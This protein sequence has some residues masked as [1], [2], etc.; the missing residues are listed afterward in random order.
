MVMNWIWQQPNWPNFTW[1]AALVDARLRTVRRAQGELSGLYKAQHHS[2][3]YTLDNLLADLLASCA[4][5]GET[6]N[7][8]SV[9]SS[10]A[11]RLG[12]SE[13]QPYPVSERSEGLADMMFDALNNGAQ[14][15]TVTRLLNWHRLLFPDESLRL[16]SIQPGEWRGH[17][18]MQVVSGR[19]DKPRVHFEAP[20]RDGL[21]QHINTFIAWFNQSSAQSSLDPLLRAALAH[22]WFVTLH[23]FEDGNGRITRALTELALAQDDKQSVRLYALSVTLL[24]NREQY[25]HRLEHT[26][27]G[28]LDVTDWCL[29][30][31][32]QLQ[33]AILAAQHQ[34][35]LTVLRARFWQAHGSTTLFAEQIKVL[36]RLLD[37]G[38]N[39]F[40]QGINA[41]QY[42]R[43]AK[44]SKAT[45][46]RH[47]SDLVTKG[48]LKKLPG[49]GR[50]T[51]YQV[52]PPDELA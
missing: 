2:A 27:R 20:P 38:Q 41:T 11:R 5:E 24:A 7:A 31:L 18:P 37:G 30:F 34:L 32:D 44:V 29:W 25:Y 36:N 14:P 1:D 19:L 17:A 6:L 4:I 26:Q 52:K 45:A 15:L 48:C 46:T 8:S 23:P 16:S 33:Q 3:T 35:E 47:L 13:Q 42:Q 10:L 28:N 43:A 9:R 22:L 21:E 51:R 50:S 40:P 39:D 12:V 49:G